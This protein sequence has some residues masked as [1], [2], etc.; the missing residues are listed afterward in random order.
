MISSPRSGVRTWSPD[1][2]SP[3]SS[4]VITPGSNNVTAS[5]GHLTELTPG[6][7]TPG[8]SA[9]IEQLLDSQGFEV[10][11]PEAAYQRHLQGILISG[12]PSHPLKSKIE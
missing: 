10:S 3:R 1:V 8:T 11:L 12:P 9:V 7:I 4:T 2:R 5:A 6:R